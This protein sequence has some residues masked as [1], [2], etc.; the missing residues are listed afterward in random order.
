MKYGTCLFILLVFGFITCDRSVTRDPAGV[1]GVWQ[2]KEI[3]SQNINEPLAND[4]LPSL[5]IFTPHH[6][7]MVWVSSEEPQ[8]AFIERWKPTDEEKIRR[9][10][11]F[12][13]NSGTYEV[14]DSYLTAYPIVARV[15]EFMGGKLVCEFQV[16]EDTLQL[17]LVDEYTYD[18]VQAPWVASGSGLILTL[19]R[20]D[21][22]PS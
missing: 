21:R 7:S 1:V 9:Y 4:S 6:Y 2:I 18:G 12:V 5:F 13:V 16:E 22:A 11:S 14:K 8:R 15:P 10:D 3:T 17:K 19:V 20:A